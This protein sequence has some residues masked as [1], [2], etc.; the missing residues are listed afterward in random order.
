M[1]WNGSGLTGGRSRPVN[2]KI[3]ERTVRQGR[4]QNKNERLFDIFF[5]I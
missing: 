4:L 5:E 3:R 2:Y 1:I